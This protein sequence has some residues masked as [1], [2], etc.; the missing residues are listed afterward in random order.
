MPRKPQAKKEEETPKRVTPKFGRHKTPRDDAG[1]SHGG[2]IEDMPRPYQRKWPTSKALRPLSLSITHFAGCTHHVPQISEESNPIWD[3]HE[4]LWRDCW[5]DID[6][7]GT[8]IEGPRFHTE[9]EAIAWLER[10]LRAFDP[11]AYDVRWYIGG[12]NLR[13]RYLNE[14]GSITEATVKSPYTDDDATDADE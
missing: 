7:K 6:G 10:M 3:T 5:D 2:A 4:D 8:R 11:K 9:P 1:S 12:A 13:W 14:D